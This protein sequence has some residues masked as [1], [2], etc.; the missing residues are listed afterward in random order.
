MCTG[1]ETENCSF[2]WYLAGLAVEF[3]TDFGNIFENL[4]EIS[5]CMWLEWTKR[6]TEYRTER[7]YEITE[8]GNDSSFR[9]SYKY[10]FQFQFPC[11][12]NSSFRL[13]LFMVPVRNRYN[14][15]VLAIGWYGK[16][17]FLC[18]YVPWKYKT[19]IA[20]A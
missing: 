13:I 3:I 15:F 5:Q 8:T 11:L 19:N 6:T 4:V 10:R 17:N 7:N 14:L 9:S 20:S 2:L 12:H 1:T 16:F 18:N